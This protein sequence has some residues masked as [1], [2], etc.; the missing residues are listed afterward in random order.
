MCAMAIGGNMQRF[1]PDLP[2]LRHTEA[3]VEAGL[4]FS[5]RFYFGAQQ[6]HTRLV[7]CIN[8]IIIDCLSV[9]KGLHKENVAEWFGLLFEHRNKCREFL[10]EFVAGY[11]KIQKPML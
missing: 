11:D 10:S 3:I 1:D 5:K 9:L 6:D 7:A 2:V 8:K 4:A